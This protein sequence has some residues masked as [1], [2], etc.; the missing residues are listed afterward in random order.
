MPADTK[1]ILT[2][3]SVI[4]TTEPH[5]LHKEEEIDAIIAAYQY[6]EMRADKYQKG[7]EKIEARMASLE[8]QLAEAVSQAQKIPQ[9]VEMAAKESYRKGFR[10]GGILGF[11]VGGSVIYFLK[12]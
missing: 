8:E 10:D 3:G 9:L 6:Q 5:F 11:V 12:R 4:T 1:I 2:D 7:F